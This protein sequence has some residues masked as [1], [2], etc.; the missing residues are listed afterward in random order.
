MIVENSV[1]NSGR[2]RLSSRGIHLR[3]I[4]PAR[5]E[6]QDARVDGIAGALRA[7]PGILVR[8]V[9]R[10][11]GKAPPAATVVPGK[12]QPEFARDILTFVRNP[13]R[14]TC[15]CGQRERRAGGDI[16]PGRFPKSPM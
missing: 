5:V 12:R 4:V 2:E 8:I 11:Y 3:L 14:E 13:I 16:E 1:V 9:I 6:Y 7:V 10:P 15:V